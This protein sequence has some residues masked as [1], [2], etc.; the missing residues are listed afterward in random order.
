MTQQ[1]EL[2]RVA[3]WFDTERIESI[4]PCGNGLINKTFV[5]KGKTKSYIFQKINTEIFHPEILMSNISSV[6]SHILSNP[7]YD[8]RCLEVVK[9]KLGT[10]YY[11]CKSGTYRMYVNISPSVCY[12]KVESAALFER[13]GLAFGKFASVLSDFN[14]AKLFEVIPNFHNTPNRMEKFKEAV[15]KDAAGRAKNVKKEIKFFLKRE[16]Y[17]H[18]IDDLLKLHLMPTRVTHNDTKLNNVLFSEDGNPIAIVD[19]D[20][21]MPGSVCYDFGD[22]IRFGCN[23]AA[24]DEPD[25]S[26][27]KFSFELFEAFTKGYLAGF[28]KITKVELDNLVW[29]AILMTYECG[30]RFLTDYLEGDMYFRVDRENQNLDRARTQIKMVKIMEAKS[31]KLQKIVQR[32]SRS[33]AVKERSNG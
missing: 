16:A 26:K 10:S 27:V 7:N 29:G 22:A 33:L 9:T 5:A 19:L 15:S 30:M 28:D 20:T 2:L 6:T 13:C 11:E 4:E 24:E 14:T 21:V 23:T 25:L 18:K 8:M 31:I 1:D 32:T 3:S 12:D 17:C